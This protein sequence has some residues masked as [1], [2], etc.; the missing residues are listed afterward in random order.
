[1]LPA[2]RPTPVLLTLPL[3]GAEIAAGGRAGAGKA[4]MGKASAGKAAGGKMGGGK[5]AAGKAR[6]Q[7]QLTIL[8]TQTREHSSPLRLHVRAFAS[9][10]GLSLVDVPDDTA[11]MEVLYLRLQRLRARGE[12]RRDSSQLTLGLG[13]LN[14][15]H[16]NSL[17]RAALARAQRGRGACTG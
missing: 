16:H 3:E 12:M 10:A 17:T 7:L 11:P 1:M 4:S 14:I 5:A 8:A 6:P 9:S 15:D 13:S 2:R